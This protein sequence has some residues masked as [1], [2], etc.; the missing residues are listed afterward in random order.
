M[1]TEKN[2]DELTIT[3][4]FIFCHVMQDKQICTE[5]LTLVLSDKI[6]NITDIAYQQSFHSTAFAKGIRLD[7]WITD[8]E[9]KTYDVEMQTTNQANLAKRLR[10]YQSIIDIT[11]LEKGKHYDELRDSFILF[12]CP[13][14]YLQKG[15]PVYTFKTICTENAGITLPDGM[16][17][18]IINSKG[19]DNEKNPELRNFLAYMNGTKIFNSP[20]I[21]KLEK[22]IQEI[23]NDEARRQEYMMLNSYTMDT[24]KKAKITIAIN[25]LRMG[26]SLENIAKAT[27]L[28]KEDIDKLIAQHKDTV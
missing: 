9:C 16:T 28:S 20:F 8:D 17:K 13:F 1:N 25:L 21:S 22:R 10:Y 26:L 4:D 27:G 3:D 7:V 5:L 19:V 11:T 23:K 18:V 24:E 14:D 15:L 2:F 6:G 12:F